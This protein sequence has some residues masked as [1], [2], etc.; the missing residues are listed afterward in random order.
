MERKTQNKELID[1]A[2]EA[3]R[4]TT[5]LVARIAR[6][7]QRTDAHHDPKAR[8]N[9]IE[10]EAHG[11]KHTFAV[12]TNPG[13]R[14]EVLAQART[15]WPKEKRPRLLV[16]APCMTDY[17]AEKCRELQLPF[18]DA[19][20][21]AYLEAG[22]LFVY[23]TGR[24]GAHYPPAPPKHRTTTAA[25][26]KILFALLCRPPLLN[27]PYRELAATAGVALGTIGP[28]MKEL[29]TRR[30]IATFRTER[31]RRHFVDAKA[32]LQEWVNFYPAILRPKLRPRRLLAPDHQRV[33]QADLVPYAAYWGGEA[34]ADRLTHYLKPETLTIYTVQDPT[35]LITDFRLRADDDGDVEILN[36]FWDRRLI[37][38]MADI[39]PA[40]LAYADLMTNADARSLD[41]A[42]LIY[43]Q[44]IAANL[45]IA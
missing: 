26:L 9:V 19:A 11:R 27:V 36:A 39:V 23:V 25:G 24:K 28:V 40:V 12:Q 31:G 3:L 13:I 43:E 18:L 33:R 10:I 35:K 41:A 45:P 37:T 29:E 15:F 34:A 17:L 5:G 7:E 6:P 22:E 14:A 16:I 4:H 21:N 32:L 1:A 30:L 8:P 42:K 44:H 2:L 20:G 38:G